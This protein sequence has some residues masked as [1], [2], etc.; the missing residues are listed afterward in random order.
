[1]LAFVVDEFADFADPSII[2]PW[3]LIAGRSAFSALS[4]RTSL[5]LASK[6]AQSRRQ[7]RKRINTLRRAKS[8]SHSDKIYLVDGIVERRD[9]CEC[10]VASRCNPY[11]PCDEGDAEAV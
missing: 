1:M 10:R 6:Q 5:I 7:T 4:P 3:A 2:P 11:S 9:D 8:H